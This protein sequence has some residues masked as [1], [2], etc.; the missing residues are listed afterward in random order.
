MAY[1]SAKLYDLIKEEKE[2]NSKKK[3]NF[4]PYYPGLTGI[5]NDTTTNS[6][7]TPS[8]T[9]PSDTPINN[10]FGVSPMPTSNIY[11]HVNVEQVASLFSS[12]FRFQMPSSVRLI[13]IHGSEVFIPNEVFELANI[14]LILS[15]KSQLEDGIFKRENNEVLDIVYMPQNGLTTTGCYV[16]YYT[17]S[18]NTDMIAVSAMTQAATRL[19]SIFKDLGIDLTSDIATMTTGARLRDVFMAAYVITLQIIIMYNIKREEMKAEK[20]RKMTPPLSDAHK[21]NKNDLLNSSNIDKIFGMPTE[22]TSFENEHKKLFDGIKPD[23][24]GM[25]NIEFGKDSDELTEI[26]DKACDY[27]SNNK[28]EVK[29]DE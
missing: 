21:L 16:S 12:A 10:F 2:M 7:G 13:T 11:S 19:I 9:R 1:V 28:K 23:E 29:K 4:N 25:F 27:E 15:I 3:E 22:E 5:P 6:W 17:S 24:N 26:I 20:L 8:G 14:S 18:D